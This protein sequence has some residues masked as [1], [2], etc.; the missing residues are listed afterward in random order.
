[1]QFKL[2][3]YLLFSDNRS[4]DRRSLLRLLFNL[5]DDDESD[6]L[7]PIEVSTWLRQVGIMQVQQ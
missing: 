5:I 6:T 4:E 2:A 7:E 1:M 3:I